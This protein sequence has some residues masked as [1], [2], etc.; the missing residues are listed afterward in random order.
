[1]NSLRCFCFVNIQHE[2]FEVYLLQIKLYHV[3]N[4]VFEIHTKI[5]LALVNTEM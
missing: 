5:V 3:T 2:L 4:F 1:M